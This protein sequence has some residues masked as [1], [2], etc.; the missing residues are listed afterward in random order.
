[1]LEKTPLAERAP[2][3]APAKPPMHPRTRMLLEAPILRRS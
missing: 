2:D 3:A 1:M